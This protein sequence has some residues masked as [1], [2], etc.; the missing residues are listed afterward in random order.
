[1]P[2]DSN[3]CGF[4]EGKKPLKSL[5]DEEF[6]IFDVETT[7]LSPVSGD[8]I[9][10]IAA[11]RMK[12]F[13]P[14]DKF[15]S[16]VNPERPISLG[17]YW[18]NGISEEMVAD[19][20]TAHRVLPRFLEFSEGACWVGHNVRFDLGFLTEELKRMDCQLEKITAIDTL[21]MARSLIPCLSSYSLASVASSLRVGYDQ[22]HRAMADVEMTTSVFSRLLSMAEE[23]K[24]AS[25]K[26][27]S[28]LFGVAY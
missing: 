26:L 1:V 15:H 3:V 8:R 19:A 12:N 7:G 13:L 4:K 22:E 21:K 11:L 23:K 5:R 18:V 28:T 25:L 14:I 17:A 27:L 24:I 6:V 9:V 10:E 20:P 2:D 16:L